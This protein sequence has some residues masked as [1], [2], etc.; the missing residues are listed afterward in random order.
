MNDQLELFDFNTP[1][2]PK[3][4]VSRCKV[5][6][7]NHQTAAR[8]CRDHHYAGRV[9]SIVASFGLWV[10]DV[11]AGVIT[12]GIPA[13]KNALSFCGD[14]YTDNGL[15]LNRL[16]VFDWAG[17]NSESYLIGQSF[18]LLERYYKSYFILISYADSGKDHI[19]YIYQATNWIYT[20]ISSGDVEFN[21]D[22]KHYHRKNA[23]NIFGTG[24]YRELSKDHDVE[25]FKQ[26][27]K[28]RYVYFLGD[29]RQRRKMRKALRWPVL[30]YPKGGRVSESGNSG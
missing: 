1:S 26:G 20:G 14:A 11:M 17:R 10:D 27:D 5:R 3:L 21:I 7:V 15:E 23:F 19:G 2:M 22:G 29:R 9:P 18:K 4:D 25:I 8:I 28:H 24:S 16:F 6:K 13:Q 12:Y 30:P